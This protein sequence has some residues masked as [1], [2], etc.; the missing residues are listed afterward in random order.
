[1]RYLIAKC[2][3]THSYD[4][5]DDSI[6]EFY[7]VKE[8]SLEKFLKSISE[9]VSEQVEINNWTYFVYSKIND[10]DIIKFD[11]IHW[12]NNIVELY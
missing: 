5:G 7:I 12:W 11:S 10:D 1:M 4:G 9:Q 3:T 2:E 8:E 6:S